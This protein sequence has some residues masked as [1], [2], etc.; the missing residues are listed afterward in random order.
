MSAQ[1]LLFKLELSGVILNIKGEKLK[2]K[3]S[4][5]LTGKQREFIKQHKKELVAGLKDRLE[6]SPEILY[7]AVTIYT[8]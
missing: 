6:W 8:G 7:Q 2:V 1:G 4:K 3:T 5:K